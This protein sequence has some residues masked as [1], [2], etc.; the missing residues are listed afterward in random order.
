[1][2]RLSLRGRLKDPTL[3][4]VQVGRRY[5]FGAKVAEHL[6]TS[7]WSLLTCIW[8]AKNWQPWLGRVL[9]FPVWI[10]VII[11]INYYIGGIPQNLHPC[12][13]PWQ[14][15]QEGSQRI[16]FES[17]NWNWS[18]GTIFL[19]TANWPT[20]HQIYTSQSFGGFGHLDRSLLNFAV[21][22]NLGTICMPIQNSL[23]LELHQFHEYEVLV[24]LVDKIF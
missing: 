23:H 7:C 16:S 1:V 2:W 4:S 18:N 20:K 9:I 17:P 14:G 19:K 12:L 11:I 5:V 10:G 13:H 15:S 6:K 24:I 21:L 8:F 3:W 22:T